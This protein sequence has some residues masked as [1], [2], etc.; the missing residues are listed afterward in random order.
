MYK[1]L[2]YNSNIY[3]FFLTIVFYLQEKPSRSA[4]HQVDL[5]LQKP[6][7]SLQSTDQGCSS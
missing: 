4:V 5:L 6:G 7:D 1:Y 2:S 3:I